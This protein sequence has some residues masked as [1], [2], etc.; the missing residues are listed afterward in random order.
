MK[1]SSFIKCYNWDKSHGLAIQQKLTYEHLFPNPAEKM[2]NHLADEVLDK[3]M[4]HLMKMY[5]QNNP[6]DAVQMAGPTE[7]FER[8]S[9]LIEIFHDRRA[10]KDSTG[11]RL[12][13]LRDILEW[14]FVMA[15]L[16][17]ES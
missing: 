8:T 13:Q 7:L 3:D 16:S 11:K 12:Q 2:R 10:I 9:V 15:I 5:V 17:R 4:L 6:D 1:W 14:F